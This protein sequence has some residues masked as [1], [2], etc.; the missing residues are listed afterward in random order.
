VARLLCVHEWE[1]NFE[2]NRTRELKALGWVPMPNRQDGDG[3]T[4]LLDHA[5]GAAHYGAWTAIVQVASKCDPR[6]TLV[7]HGQKPHDSGSLARIT[8]IP[9]EVFDE[10]I[11]R[12]IDIGWLD[13]V[14]DDVDESCDIPHQPAV[15]PHP[16]AVAPHLPAL[17]GMEGKEQNGMEKKGTEQKAKPGRAA[18]A[19]SSLPAVPEPILEVFAHYRTYHARAFPVPVPSSKEWKLIAARLKEG[20]SVDDLRRAIDG[21]HASPFHCGENDGN[22]KYNSLELIVRDGSKVAAF[23]DLASQS[24]GPVLSEKTARTKRAAEAFIRS[25]LGDDHDEARA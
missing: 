10:A 14:T 23:M 18:A 25:Q 15:I 4:E 1:A 5:N 6:G 22:K 16:V 19:A 8:R 24:G 17:N 21:N 9:K 3:Y 2:N 12:L 20:Y 13:A 7:R 11:P